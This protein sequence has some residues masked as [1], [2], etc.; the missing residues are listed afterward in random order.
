MRYTSIMIKKCNFLPL[1]IM[2]FALCIAQPINASANE[3]TVLYQSPPSNVLP[4]LPKPDKSLSN[5]PALNHLL[6]EKHES[7]VIEDE[8][9]K[10]Y[11]ERDPKNPRVMSEA[12]KELRSAEH[13][14]MRDLTRKRRRSLAEPRDNSHLPQNT[15][16][17]TMQPSSYQQDTSYIQ[18]SISE[19][20]FDVFEELLPDI[21]G[22][23]LQASVEQKT[24]SSRIEDLRVHSSDLPP[25]M[26]KPNSKKNISQRFNANSKSDPNQTGRTKKKKRNRKKTNGM[27]AVNDLFNDLQ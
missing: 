7:P 25:Y 24:K 19:E 8:I 13:T 2:L 4:N 23:E 22:E 18:S 20:E 16:R 17:L 27:K 5:N 9:E 6:V 11:Q 15:R 12:L 21:Y 26:H 14:A 10:D 1:L 3:G